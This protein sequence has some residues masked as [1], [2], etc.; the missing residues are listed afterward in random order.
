MRFEQFLNALDMG[1]C[2]DKMQCQAIYDMA[3]MLVMI[4]GETDERELSLMASWL[5]DQSWKGD[6][7]GAEYFETVKS[8][9]E[10]ALDTDTADDFITHRVSQL[11]DEDM[12][13]KALTLAEAIANADGHL[14]DKELAAIE[15]IKSSLRR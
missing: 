7:P 1:Q 10:A 13:T 2:V 9:C 8:K 5:E 12:Q 4:D 15:L 6:I 3:L 11:V 14:H